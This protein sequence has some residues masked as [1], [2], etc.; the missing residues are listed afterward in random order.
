MKSVFLF[1]IPVVML[2]SQ[3]QAGDEKK[4]SAEM[5][6]MLL[7]EGGTFRMGDVFDE[8]LPHASPVHAV[9][10]SSFFLNRFS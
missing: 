4:R 1:A 6:D 5:K 2:C 7:I 9:T 8:G 3:W 10:I